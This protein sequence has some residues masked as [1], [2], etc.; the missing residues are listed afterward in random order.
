MSEKKLLTASE[1]R[2]RSLKT[3]KVSPS[4]ERVVDNIHNARENGRFFV[5]IIGTFE[6]R[7]DFDNIYQVLMHNGYIVEDKSI[8]SDTYPSLETFVMKISW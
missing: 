7:V 1:S 4:Y 2:E 5:I 6:N 3:F 8:S